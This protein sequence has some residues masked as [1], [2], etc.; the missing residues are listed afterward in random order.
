MQV[1]TKI[2]TKL[3]CL[4]RKQVSVERLEEI[5]CSTLIQPHFDRACA[6]RYPVQVR[7]TPFLQL[8]SFGET[9]SKG[10]RLEM[11][12]QNSTAKQSFCIILKVVGMCSGI[13]W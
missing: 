4:C 12:M 3:K 5:L 9:F 11:Q 2:F 8:A 1:C 6:A 10:M 13:I 7:N